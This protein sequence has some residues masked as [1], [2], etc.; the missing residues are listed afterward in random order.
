MNDQLGTK[1]IS[2]HGKGS[3]YGKAGVLGGHIDV[4]IANVGEVKVPNDNK[5]LKAIA[6][7]SPERS[8]FMPDVPTLKEK[9]YGEIYS[10]SGRGIA[11][12]KGM[13]EDRKVILINAFK[14]AIENEG[15]VEKMNKLGLEVV[16][17]FGED[18]KQFCDADEQSVI[19]V[20]GLLGW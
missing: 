13:P 5:E 18:F 17:I 3:A 6:V 2:V 8:K 14:N 20:K 12:V 10:W 11:G 19:D 1:F 16:P 7:L 9:E 4:Y 15:F